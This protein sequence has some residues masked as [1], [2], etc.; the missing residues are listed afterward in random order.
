MKMREGIGYTAQPSDDG[1]SW[2]VWKVEE[3]LPPKLVIHGTMED[4]QS[5]A[6]ALNARDDAEA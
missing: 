1:E 3:G 2:Y 6:D 5:Y 4:C